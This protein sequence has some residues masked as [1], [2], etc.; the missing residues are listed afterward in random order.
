MSEANYTPQARSETGFSFTD[1]TIPLPWIYAA[2][3]TT[4]LIAPTAT[5]IHL[6]E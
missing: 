4:L 1:A 5:A 2:A 3:G 6:D